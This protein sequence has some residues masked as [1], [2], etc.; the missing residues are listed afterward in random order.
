VRRVDYNTSAAGAHQPVIRRVPFAFE[1]VRIHSGTI[2]TA[3]VSSSGEIASSV[4][5][6][7]QLPHHQGTIAD[8]IVTT[9]LPAKSSGEPRENVMVA[10]TGLLQSTRNQL[11]T[12]TGESAIT[13]LLSVIVC[14]LIMAL[15]FTCFVDFLRRS[16][17]ALEGHSR[18]APVSKADISTALLRAYDVHS[19]IGFGAFGVVHEVTSKQDHKKYAMKMVDLSTSDVGELEQEAEILEFI[20]HDKYT[21]GCVDI[22]Q[23]A[24]FFYFVMPLYQGGD[25]TECLSKYM[26]TSGLIPEQLFLRLFQQMVASVSYVHSMRVI[27]CDVKPDNFLLTSMDLFDSSNRIA[28]ADFGCSS[29]LTPGNF[30]YEKCG[31]PCFFSPEVLAGR[32]RFEYDIWALGLTAYV[33]VTGSYA[34]KGELEIQEWMESNAKYPFAVPDTSKATQHM[35]MRAVARSSK[36][37]ATAEELQVI[38]GKHP[39]NGV[40]LEAP[41]G[42]A[43]KLQSAPLARMGSGVL[44]RLDRMVKSLFEAESVPDDH[45]TFKPFTYAIKGSIARH[46]DWWSVTKCV[47][48]N[49]GVVPSFQK[50][51]S[52]AAAKSKDGL[53]KTSKETRQWMETSSEKDVSAIRKILKGYGVD[54]EAFGKHGAKSLEDFATE[55]LRGGSYLSEDGKKLTRVIHVGTLVLEGPGDKILVQ[56][57]ARKSSA[58]S[59]E[60]TGL[61]LPSQKI[62]AHDDRSAFVHD[63]IRGCDIDSETEV[64]LEKEKRFFIRK[65]SS[66]SFPGIQTYY[67]VD[68]R[69][70]RLAPGLSDERLEELGIRVGVKNG[71]VVGA[72]KRL[73]GQKKIVWVDRN[74]FEDPTRHDPAPATKT[75]MVRYMALQPASVTGVALADIVMMLK[76]CKLDPISFD[77]ENLALLSKEASVGECEL[78]VTTDKNNKSFLTRHV[79][80]ALLYILA[81]NESLLVE[82]SKAAGDGSIADDYGVDQLPTVKLRALEH[83]CAGARREMALHIGVDVDTARFELLPLAESA[84]EEIS[85]KGLDFDKA[86]HRLPGIRTVLHKCVVV[87]RLNANSAKVH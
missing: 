45:D 65:E 51:L 84:L 23:D 37:R 85:R 25:I 16:R 59:W 9:A 15:A 14:G 42:G 13:L 54:A 61:A 48:R 26:Q 83:P 73:L 4:S 1:H 66:I 3:T 19:M 12:A 71:F 10:V 72:A 75:E 67:L 27:H 29:I 21:V 36:N 81:P 82:V 35:L 28:L 8:D 46:Y 79:R 38:A 31:T 43:I 40:D 78:S 69:R 50:Y 32:Y 47:D 18:G 49:V 87:V 17:Q 53:K 63:L 57:A 64:V 2:A 55:V 7:E 44:K 20:R 70:A 77:V 24:C 80:I 62:Y 60:Q 11:V 74:S 41:T 58:H 52:D 56:R 39:M 76:Q 5:Y 30:M 33:L 34:F 86:H 6:A 22:R 68:Q